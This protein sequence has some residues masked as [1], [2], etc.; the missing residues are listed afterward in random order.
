M[1]YVIGVV[2]GLLQVHLGTVHIHCQGAMIFWSGQSLGVTGD[3]GGGV[4]L[5]AQEGRCFDVYVAGLGNDFWSGQSLMSVDEPI[6]FLKKL[7][8]FDRGRRW[9]YD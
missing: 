8:V 2:G 7:G 9:K 3:R 4:Y 1:L 5:I 6:S